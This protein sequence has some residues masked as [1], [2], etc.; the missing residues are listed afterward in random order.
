MNAYS[1]KEHKNIPF[2]H[3]EKHDRPIIDFYIAFNIDD[4]QIK[5]KS[6]LYLLS[7]MLLRGTARFDKTS[8][9]EKIDSMGA[10]LSISVGNHSIALEGEVLSKNYFNLLDLCLSAL[11]EPLLSEYEFKKLLSET[12]SKL[13]QSSESDA[14]LAKKGF[15]SL[16]YT[17]HPYADQAWGTLE[18]LEQVNIS[19]IKENYKNFISQLSITFGFS[20]DVEQSS[21]HKT[22]DLFSQN[23][24]VQSFW[25]IPEKKIPHHYSNEKKLLVIDK[26]NRSQC[27]FFIGHP[28]FN[29]QHPDYY[30]LK[31]F[32]MAF[33]GGIFQAKYMQEIRVKR[34]WAYGAYGSLSLHRDLGSL[35]LYTYPEEK[36]TIDAIK[37]SLE[38]MQ[39]AIDGDLLA[40][41]DIEFAKNYMMKSFPFKIDTPQKIMSEMLYHKMLNLDENRLFTYRDKIKALSIKEIRSAAKK[42][43]H[44]DQFSIS[45]LATSENIKNN[46]DNHF[47]DWNIIEKN[48]LDI[49]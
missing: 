16:V 17:D 22:I 3:V 27:H 31:T 30:A 47:K 29:Y 25:E 49:L 36:D 32:M 34:G 45:L 46:L 28:C 33:A 19:D 5:N 40:D 26:P 20:G 2:I 43:I 44:I 37:L 11:S 21:I 4:L 13:K 8:F 48:Y 18:S 12:K 1:W 6:V 39:Q 9:N 35:F 7:Q 15:L 42:H 14:S 23:L 41:T 38:L 24:N 10:S